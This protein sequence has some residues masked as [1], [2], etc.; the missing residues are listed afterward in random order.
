MAPEPTEVPH[1]LAASLAPCF[2]R[3][4]LLDREHICFF[5]SRGAPRVGGVVGAL[6]FQWGFQSCWERAY[7]FPLVLIRAGN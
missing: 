4:V 7:F 3:G 1:E 2:S 6:F 5:C